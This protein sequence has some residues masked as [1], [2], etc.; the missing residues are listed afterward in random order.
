MTGPLEG[1]RVI[2]IAGIGPG[3]FCAMLLADLGADVLRIDRPR[4][5]PLGTPVA[6]EFDI[7]RR[8]RR[9]VAVDLAHA[10]GAGVVL[11]LVDRADA[12][13]E[14]FR[15]GVA[16]RLGIGPETCL[17]RNPRLVYG[18]M[19]GW[20]QDGPLAG[21]A[22]HDAN[23]VALTGALHAIGQTDGP[24]VPPLNLIGDYG[25]GALYLA[26]G[27]LAAVFEAGRSGRGQVVDAA[28]VDGAASLMA[29]VYGRHAAGLW[30]D[31]RGRNV[32]DGGA[33]FYGVYE[34]RDAK[35][36]A[37]AAIEPKFYAELL[38]RI[39]LVGD[40]LPE[41][42]DEAAWPGM[43]ARF[44]AV[45][46]ER[47]RDQWQELLEGTDACF[48][49]VLSLSEAALHPH[50]ADRGTFVDFGGIVQPAPAPRF[51]RTAPDMRLPPSTPGEHTVDALGDWGFASREIAVLR[52]SGAIGRRD[53]D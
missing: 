21:A 28:M 47:T 17:E 7:T 15:P 46:K 53:D 8:N 32:L 13:I 2:E 20:G 18:R 1:L 34:T 41:Q 25:G 4:E 26:L 24:P 40:D 6:P 37:I 27:I 42:W 38:E 50:M 49:P 43:R 14:G 33:H 19:T 22:G 51:S 52:E 36:V 16:E 11:R 44:E 48:A 23:Y 39:G 10:D 30:R 45:F 3:P 29:P 9:S 31:E 5:V 12:L 35:H